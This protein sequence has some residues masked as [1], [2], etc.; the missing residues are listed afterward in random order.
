M[1]SDFHLAVGR[2]DLLAAA[3]SDAKDP[4]AVQGV[5][6][7]AAQPEGVKFLTEQLAGAD[8]EKVASLLGGSGDKAA[9]KVL[10]GLFAK[11]SKADAKLRTAAVK[12]LSLS[13]GGATTLVELAEKNE[14]PEDAKTAARSALAMVHYPNLAQRMAKVF[15]APQAAGGMALPPIV[16]LMKMKGDASK[17]R[18]L[19]AKAESSCTLCHRVG[20]TGVDFAP[21]LSEI[22]TKLGKDA[23]FDSILNPNAGISMGFETT[24]LK[25]KNGSS[26][27]GIVR[28]ET[29]GNVVLV[30][31]GGVTNSFAKQEI[32][33]RSKLPVSMM[34]TG[35]QALF[36]KEQLVD[37]VEYLSSLKAP[38]GKAAATTAAKK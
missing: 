28:S 20:N 32:A 23:I 27:L 5:K 30:L 36:T 13:A 8:G 26:A 19:F 1:A 24:E 37:L 7:I 29:D 18:E 2:E 38:A 3:L 33:S 4:R 22:G 31:P 35:L 14:L 12:A 21:G 25:L 11:G 9:L 10:A 17:G 15:P 6:L 34:P 16:E